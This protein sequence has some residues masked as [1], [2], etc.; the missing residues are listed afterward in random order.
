MTAVVSGERAKAAGLTGAAGIALLVAAIVMMI[1][2]A[3]GRPAARP[4]AARPAVVQLT[5]DVCHQLTSSRDSAAVRACRTVA[6][7]ARPAAARP[8]WPS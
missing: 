2:A 1:V 8:G 6:P 4:A 3:P 5:T 7:G